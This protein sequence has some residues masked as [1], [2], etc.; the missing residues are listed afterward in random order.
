[1]KRKVAACKEEECDRGRSRCNKSFR[2]RGMHKDRCGSNRGLGGRGKCNE[3]MVPSSGHMHGDRVWVGGG[4]ELIS[5]Q[6]RKTAGCKSLWWPP[7]RLVHHSF[8]T[9]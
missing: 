2:H 3:A 4:V 5:N 7:A 6:L 9:K 8:S 1:M